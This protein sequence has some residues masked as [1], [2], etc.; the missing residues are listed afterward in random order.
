M[1]KLMPNAAIVFAADHGGS[2]ARN[3]EERKLPG[4]GFPSRRSMLRKR[5]DRSTG[6]VDC[7]GAGGT[8]LD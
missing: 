5:F 1:P 3:A 4:V 2:H 6:K 8:Y 7:S